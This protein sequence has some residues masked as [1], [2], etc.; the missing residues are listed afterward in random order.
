MV[1][2]P[3]GTDQVSIVEVMADGETRLIIWGVDG[4]GTVR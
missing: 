2:Q 1:D 3:D 4:G